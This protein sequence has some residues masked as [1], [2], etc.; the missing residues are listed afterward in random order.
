M[1]AWLHMKLSLL[2][3]D[4]NFISKEGETHYLIERTV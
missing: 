1:V 4:N 2:A 3:Q